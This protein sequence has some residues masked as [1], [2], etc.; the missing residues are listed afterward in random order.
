M[1]SRATVLS[2]KRIT[3]TIK[4]R[5]VSE[6]LVEV[7]N[8]CP[9]QAARAYEAQKPVDE[10]REPVLKPR[11]ESDV[12]DEP[13]EPRDPAGEPHPVRAEDRA[14]AIHGGH[15]PE[16]SV[17]PGSRFG[18]LSHTISDDMSSMQ[19]GLEGNLGNTWEVV[20]VH[21]VADYEHLRVAG[22]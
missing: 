5:V 8:D 7:N 16:V 1:G 22:Q 14:A 19:T 20:A 4:S 15:T 9:F 21:H 3:T 11:H 18:A 2:N 12:H 17:L 13:H 6:Q 10:S